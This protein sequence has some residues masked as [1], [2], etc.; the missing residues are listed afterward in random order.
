MYLSFV[1]DH[2]AC[3]GQEPSEFLTFVADCIENPISLLPEL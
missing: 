3:D 1:F 2:R